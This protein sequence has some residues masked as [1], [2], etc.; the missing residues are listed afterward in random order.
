VVKSNF[1]Q[2]LLIFFFLIYLFIYW[3][4][5]VFVGRWRITRKKMMEN[6]IHY[7][8]QIIP[9]QLIISKHRYDIRLAYERFVSALYVI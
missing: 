2:F 8:P 7:C 1:V 3:R 5:G 4:G 9:Y 6:F